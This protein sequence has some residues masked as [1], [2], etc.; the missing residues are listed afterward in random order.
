MNYHLR[1]KLLF[2][3]ISKKIPWIYTNRTIFKKIFRG[4]ER[5]SLRITL[6]GKQSITKHPNLMGSPLTHK[7]ITTDFS[8]N[9]LEF[10]TPKTRNINVLLSFLKDLY[11]YT[12]KN[13]NK[14][15][16]WSLSMPFFD[17]NNQHIRIADYGK[18]NI[19]I[20]KKIYR[21][22][23]K[24]RY[25]TYMNT[26]AGVHYNF[27]LP[28]SFWKTWKGIEDS[29]SEK[30]TISNGYLGLIRNYYRFGWII[31]YLFGSS[32]TIST[33]MIKNNN[34]P[35][36]FVDHTKKSLYMPWATSL[37]V[38]SIGYQNESLKKLQI[39]FNSLSDYINQLKYG[40][41]TPVPKYVKIGIKDKQGNFKQINTNLLQMENELYSQ[42]RPKTKI[43]NNES[44][45]NALEKRGIKYVEIRSLDVNPFSSIGINKNQIIFLDLFLIWCLLIDSPPIDNLELKYIFKNWETIA[46]KGRRKDISIHIKSEKEKIPFI[47]IANL[48]LLDLN[49]IARV[50]DEDHKFKDYQCIC[51]KVKNCINNP[52]L[53]YSSKILKYMI[54]LGMKET[55]LYFSNKYYSEHILEP[56]EYIT[57]D[58]FKKEYYSSLNLQSKIEEN[59]TT[60]NI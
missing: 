52:N 12:C 20:K 39:K 57:D 24:Y 9:F 35:F 40:M 4:I 49:K 42:I 16:L 18:S 7:W 23:L 41:N 8:E 37:R 29:K 56:Y 38:S 44:F 48:I 46:I 10:I 53:T 27:S 31:P 33:N 54:N 19:G 6:N 11:R 51:K 2:S 30:E 47:K 45:I 14:E 25:G 60:K 59:N 43:L 3:N 28:T 13:I 21:K 1:I 5:E 50:F 32:P 17:S 58:M 22:G 15:L 26:I 36:N 55:G 34:Y